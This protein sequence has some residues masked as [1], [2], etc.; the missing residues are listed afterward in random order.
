LWVFGPAR[1]LG[2]YWLKDLTR[3]TKLCQNPDFSIQWL[4]KTKVVVNA[5]KD[6]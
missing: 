4:D 5:S 2:F 3:K 1:L 6:L